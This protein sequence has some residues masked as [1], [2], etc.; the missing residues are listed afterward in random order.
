MGKCNI[1]ELEGAELLI[2]N[3]P[4][5]FVRGHGGGCDLLIRVCRV[6]SRKSDEKKTDA[7]V[8]QGRVYARKELQCAAKMYGEMGLNNKTEA[9][10]DF[11]LSR[12]CLGVFGI[13]LALATHRPRNGPVP[14]PTNPNCQQQRARLLLKFHFLQQFLSEVNCMLAANEACQEPIVSR[15]QASVMLLFCS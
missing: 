2:D 5:D 6:Y 9:A 14:Y 10:G 8:L 12:T 11:F 1:L 4:H 13:F 3:L 7:P 15:F